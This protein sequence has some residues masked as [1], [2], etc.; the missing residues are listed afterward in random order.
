MPR[1]G[2]TDDDTPTDVAVATVESELS[3]AIAAGWD[4]FQGRKGPRR[5]RVQCQS[6]GG[7]GAYA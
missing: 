6:A 5:E 7:A 2:P 4:S 1:V 3:G